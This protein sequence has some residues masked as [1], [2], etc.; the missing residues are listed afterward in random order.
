MRRSSIPP[1]STLGARYEIGEVLVWLKA[2]PQILPWSPDSRF[3]DLY[4]FE[5]QCRRGRASYAVF[6][7]RLLIYSSFVVFDAIALTNERSGDRDDD[8]DTGRSTGG[9]NL[10]WSLKAS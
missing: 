5:T 6:R 9:G 8:Q 4:H 7:L 3:A 2:N 10:R 1:F